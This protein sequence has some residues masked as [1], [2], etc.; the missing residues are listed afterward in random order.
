MILITAFQQN[1]IFFYCSAA[2]LGLLVGSFLNVVIF[3]LP[4]MME[5]EWRKECRLLLEIDQAEE[6]SE[7]SFNLILPRS[8]CPHCKHRISALENIP[9][10]SYLFLKGRC[11]QCKEKISIRYPLVELTSCI[12]TV[13]VAMHF[14]VTYQALLA[15]LL[16]WSLLVM[17]LIDYD[18]KIIPDDISLPLLWVGIIANMFGMFTNIESSLYGAIFGYLSLWSVYILFKLLTGKEGMGFGDFKLLAML[19]AWLGWQFLPLIIIASSLFGTLVGGGLVLFR[20]HD[21]AHPIPFGPYLAM[22]GFISLLYGQELINLYL[23][24]ALT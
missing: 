6:T 22:A 15:M 24:W 11:S 1:P 16:T 3:R 14:G 9:V 4:R 23:N 20:S 17:S 18:H 2:I 10:I 19:G 8:T 12:L 13:M 5:R 21:R 7:E